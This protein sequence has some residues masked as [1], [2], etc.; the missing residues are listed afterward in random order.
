[1]KEREYDYILIERTIWPVYD[2]FGKSHMR[3][4]D[5]DQSECS[6]QI[7]NCG[8]GLKHFLTRVR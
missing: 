8:C 1:M 6:I 5:I 3:N 4:S 7:A 2:V